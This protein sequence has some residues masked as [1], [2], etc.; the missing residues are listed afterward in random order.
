M[1]PPIFFPC[2]LKNRPFQKEKS[3]SQHF[4]WGHS[5]VFWGND[6]SYKAEVIL[7]A[8]D[9]AAVVDFVEQ[10]TRISTVQTLDRAV[11]VV[12]RS[13]LLSKQVTLQLLSLQHVCPKMAMFSMLMRL[14]LGAMPGRESVFSYKGSSKK[15]GSQRGARHVED[16][17]L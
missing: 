5:Y 6:S 15:V 3:Q 10:K 11:G 12:G 4:S 17:N 8:G 13:V 16:S 9:D 2:H 7:G 14:C 1:L